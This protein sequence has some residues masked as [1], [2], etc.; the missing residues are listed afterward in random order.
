[1]PFTMSLTCSTVDRREAEAVVEVVHA[2]AEAAEMV[3]APTEPA[4]VSMDG[5]E[6]RLS[7]ALAAGAPPPVPAVAE[8][9]ETA[10]AP[11]DSAVPSMD[12]VDV[13]RPTAPA[14]KAAV[15]VVSAAPRLRKLSSWVSKTSIKSRRAQPTLMLSLKSNAWQECV[16]GIDAPCACGILHRH[17]R[18]NGKLD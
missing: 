1:M 6:R 12:G 8:T 9:V 17:L 18:R 3:F 11:M 16:H 14:V 2:V 5:A 13:P 10:F 4:A 7:I 15:A